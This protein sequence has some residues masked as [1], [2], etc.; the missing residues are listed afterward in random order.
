MPRWIADACRTAGQDP[1]TGRGA[2]V[3]SILL[4]LACKYRWVMDHLEQ[5][6][7]RALEAVYVTGGGAKNTLLCQLTADV[8]GRPVHAGPVEASALGS[9]L[10]QARAAGLF[11]S[12]AEMR[13][14]A[15]VTA[16]PRAYEPAPER[17]RS[18]ETYQ[19][20]LEVTGLRIPAPA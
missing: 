16:R 17:D 19:R 3:R 20:F 2:V 15:L 14:A 4:S 5:V 10:V 8:T 18:A 13:E 6:T 1:P 11:G 9:V 12:L 7:G